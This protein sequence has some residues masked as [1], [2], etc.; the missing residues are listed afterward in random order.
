MNTYVA[1]INPSENQKISHREIQRPE[2]SLLFF[3][4]FWGFFFYS[5]S[6]VFVYKQRTVTK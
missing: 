3:V 5:A 2:S 1:T 4:V 6:L